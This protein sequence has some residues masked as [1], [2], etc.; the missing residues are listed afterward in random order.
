MEGYIRNPNT[1]CLICSKPIYRRPNE[2]IRNNG[3]VFCSIVCYGKFCRKEKPCLVC[4]T[5]IMARFNKKTCSRAC[6]NKHREGI[7]YK[8]GHPHDKVVYTQGLK[9]RLLKQRGG[10]CERCNYS[11]TEI[12]VVHHKDRDRTHNDLDNLE[13]ICP[14]CHY[15]EHYLEKSWLN[16][17][18]LHH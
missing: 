6:A 9:F 14:N 11:K 7:K 4:G 1:A 16:G 8:M 3:H 2:L 17:Y 15:E 10:N 12:L 18:N 5:L 13:L